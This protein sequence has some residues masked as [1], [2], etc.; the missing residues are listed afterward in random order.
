MRAVLL[1]DDSAVIRRVLAPR[2]AS[3][4]F[5]VREASAAADVRDS[6]ANLVACAIIDL[7]LAD[8]DG[9]DVAA[10]LLATRRSLPVA[11]FTSSGD[12]PL[13]ERARAHGPVFEKPNVDAI[14]A[15]AKQVAQPPPTK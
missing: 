2:L 1:V 7:E 9:A 3:E 12:S 8:R 11:F 10:S 14:V 5:V 6:D 4:G 15:W 13:R